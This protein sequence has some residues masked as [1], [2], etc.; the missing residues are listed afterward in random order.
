MTNI[1]LITQPEITYIQ[2]R[3]WKSLN[4][5]N[6]NISAKTK[7]NSLSVCC[8]FTLNEQTLTG[9]QSHQ[10][11]LPTHRCTWGN[12]NSAMVQSQL[13]WEPE[14]PIVCLFKLCIMWFDYRVNQPGWETTTAVQ[15]S[16]AKA[17]FCCPFILPSSIRAPSFPQ[18]FHVLAI[19]E[20]TEPHTYR[21]NKVALLKHQ[22]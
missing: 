21:L 22:H 12:K 16:T 2:F 14:C 7:I 6:K 5:Y 1:N 8:F 20:Q 13:S 15:Y 11:M 18:H 3:P 10:N 9:A 19:S 4:A 17:P